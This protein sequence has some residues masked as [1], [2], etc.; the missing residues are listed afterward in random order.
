MQRAVNIYD[1]VKHGDPTRWATTTV[2]E[3]T[4]LFYTQPSF[5][6]YYT[7]HKYLMDNSLHYVAT[8]NYLKTQRLAVR[9]ERDVQEIKAVHV[10]ITEYRDG[11]RVNGP[12]RQFI[13][14][15]RRV[16]REYERLEQEGMRRDRGP[17][18]AEPMKVEWSEEDQL[19]LRFLLRSCQ[20]SQSNQCDPF[21]AGRNAIMKLLVPHGPPL[22]DNIVVGVIMKLVQP[23]GR[24]CGEERAGGGG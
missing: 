3:V 9:P 7:T 4:H 20:P 24:L 22:Q 8:P 13:R 21:T 1:R 19:F 16:L 10:H 17:V 11:T 15:A 18:E 5:I 12:F 6:D 14:K 2:S 23:L